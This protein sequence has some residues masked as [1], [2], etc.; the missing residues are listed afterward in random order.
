MPPYI[1]RTRKRSHFRSFAG[2]IAWKAAEQ[3]HSKG[4][5]Q[6]L[7]ATREPVQNRVG[8]PISTRPK[9]SSSPEIPIT[10]K[11]HTQDH[12]AEKRHIRNHFNPVGIT[13]NVDQKNE[14]KLSNSAVLVV[15]EKDSAGY[16]KHRV[17]K[18]STDCV[19]NSMLRGGNNSQSPQQE[20]HKSGVENELQS[21]VSS[22]S[23]HKHHRVSET[24]ESDRRLFQNERLAS[25]HSDY[26]S[27]A[28]NSSGARSKRSPTGHSSKLGVKNGSQSPEKYKGRTELE[29]DKL[30]TGHNQHFQTHCCAGHFCYFHDQFCLQTVRQILAINASKNNER[31]CYNY[32]GSTRNSSNQEAER[33]PPTPTR[34][35]GAFSYPTVSAGIDQSDCSKFSSHGSKNDSRNEFK[36]NC[37]GCSNTAYVTN[38]NPEKHAGVEGKVHGGMGLKKQGA[39][40]VSGELA[41]GTNCPN[42]VPVKIE[43]AELEHTQR[44]EFNCEQIKQLHENKDR[45]D[46]TELT[47]ETVKTR[48][49]QTCSQFCHFCRGKESSSSLLTSADL[50]DSP[51]DPNLVRVDQN[52][53]FEGCKL[54]FSGLPGR[55]KYPQKAEATASFSHNCPNS[56]QH[57]LQPKLNESEIKHEVAGAINYRPANNL[58]TRNLQSFVSDLPKE[59]RGNYDVNHVPSQSKTNLKRS[60]NDSQESKHSSSLPVLSYPQICNNSSLF[61][62]DASRKHENSRSD[63]LITSTKPDFRDLTFEDCNNKTAKTTPLFHISDRHNSSYAEP[64]FCQKQENIARVSKIF[65]ASFHSNSPSP[66]GHSGAA[67]ASEDHNHNHHVANI[68]P[69]SDHYCACRRDTPH[70]SDLFSPSRSD[71]TRH[72]FG[73]KRHYPRR[74]DSDHRLSAPLVIR[75]PSLDDNSPEN[76]MSAAESKPRTKPAPEKLNLSNSSRTS[77][78]SPN[79]NFLNKDSLKLPKINS[80]PCSLVSRDSLDR[81]VIN[82]SGLKF[83]TRLKTLER[84]PNSLLGDP[85]KRLKYFDHCRNEFFFDRNRAAFEAVIYYYQSNGRLRKPANLPVEIFI[86]ELKFY[87]IER[88][89]IQK[90]IEDEGYVKEPER[91]LPK[92]PTLR[93]MWLLFEFPESSRAARIVAILSVTIILL[94]IVTFCTETLP[95]FQRFEKDTSLE[96]PFFVIETL[97]VIWFSLEL[98]CRAVSSPSK[99]H[100]AK[101]LMN[102]FDL[103]AILPYFIQIGTVVFQQEDNADSGESKAMSLAIL[104]VIRL[105]RVFRI[106]KL[107]RHSKGLQI[108]GKTLKASLR[109]LGLLIFFLGIGVILFSSAVFFAED[110]GD[111][112]NLNT[113]FKSI[114]DAFWWAVVT[115]TTVGYGDI[116][117]RSFPGKIVGSLC[118]IAGVLTIALPVPV[119]V[120]NFNYF[121]HREHD[122]EDAEKFKL[123]EEST[124]PDTPYFDKRANKEMSKRDLDPADQ[125]PEKCGQEVD[126]GASGSGNHLDSGV[127]DAFNY[128]EESRDANDLAMVAVD[129]DQESPPHHND[130]RI[131]IEIGDD[132]S[133]VVELAQLDSS[134]SPQSSKLPLKERKKRNLDSAGSTKQ[135][136]S[137]V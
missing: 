77:S 95:Q 5:R 68:A 74:H 64:K 114:P 98:S 22:P 3:N 112:D 32:P 111:P 90:F 108:L 63:S 13:E 65:P 25:K 116:L 97:C 16:E 101:N 107:S 21:K 49:W 70:F 55:R 109:E 6:S 73:E 102:A 53:C 17:R 71:H 78:S 58:L 89:V 66:F 57:F 86:E 67:S 137:L 27:F 4:R 69:Y 94:S 33:V 20:S 117:P 12:L 34:S 45:Q 7:S 51:L 100:F 135:D 123:F 132:D 9:L 81:A 59:D 28:G 29:R 60:S 72:F 84:F 93:L 52:F 136:E 14:R 47:H 106:F 85:T 39:R 131:D 125:D 88:K 38:R 36:G 83:E 35:E 104:R 113:D 30:L 44:S 124:P 11:H 134:I 18:S 79:P 87:E 24:D 126:L 133:D 105:V 54:Q 19:R 99:F 80:G 103:L 15:L 2:V 50:S 82:I 10:E 41:N 46:F 42:S 129:K 48:A 62:N 40:L 96:N 75:E 130:V 92:H 128:Q 91:P 110:N 121:Y 23:D 1:K 120:S 26:K 56:T 61:S 118:A 119:I 122:A 127:R 31:I 37:A 76:L 43:S 8:G 115:M